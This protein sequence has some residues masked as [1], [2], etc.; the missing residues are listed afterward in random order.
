MLFTAIIEINSYKAKNVK[1]QSLYCTHY[2][3]LNKQET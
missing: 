2:N 1:K 3:E